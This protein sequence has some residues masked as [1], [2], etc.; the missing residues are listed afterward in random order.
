MFEKDAMNIFPVGDA[1]VFSLE[2]FLSDESG[3]N[4][5]IMSF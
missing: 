5:V 2:G 4:D 1:P 3:K